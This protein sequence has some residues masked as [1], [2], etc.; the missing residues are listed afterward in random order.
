VAVL[1]G[2]SPV[3]VVADLERSVA[4]YTERLGFASEVH[5]DPPNFATASRDGDPDGYDIAF[6]QR[7]AP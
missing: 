6:G 1:T 5:G 2:I 4:Y 7:I 3:L